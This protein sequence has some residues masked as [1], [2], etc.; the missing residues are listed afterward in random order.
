GAFR[1]GD[2]GYFREVQYISKWSR[3]ISISS[4]HA[5]AIWAWT[6]PKVG[7]SNRGWVAI[8]LGLIGKLATS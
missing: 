2:E 5:Q 1:I 7:R 8:L 4:I 3:G 6:S